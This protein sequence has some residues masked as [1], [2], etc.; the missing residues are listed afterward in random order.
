MRVVCFL[1]L[2]ALCS[3]GLAPVW[4]A[5]ELPILVYAC[6]RIQNAPTTTR[7]GRLLQ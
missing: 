6:P 1:L 7:A 2:G 4:A 5:D 3:A